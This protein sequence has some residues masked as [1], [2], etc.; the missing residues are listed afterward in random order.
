MKRVLIALL[1]SCLSVL[2]AYQVELTGRDLWWPGELWNALWCSV[3]VKDSA[4]NFIRKLKLEDF[5]LKER[6]YG[7]N[8]E[9]LS[10]EIKTF[11][12][13][14]SYKFNGTG[15]WEKSVNS[16]KLDIV[17]FID[18]TGSMGKHIDSIKHQLH[19]FIDRLFETGT[20]FRIFISTYETEDAPEWTISSYTNR[21]FG[22]TMVDEI[23]Q[24]IDEIDTAG[25]WWNLTWG[26]DAFL[27]SLNLDWRE[28][29]RKIVVIITDV[30]TD[31]VY[32]PNWYFSSGCVTSMNAVDLAIRQTHIQLYYCQ[33][34]EE[35]M[36]KTELSENYSSKVNIKVKQSNFDQLAQKN[37]MVKKLSWPF[38]Q[39]EIELKNLPVID[40]KY[41]F[42]WVSDWSKQRFVERVE[43]QISLNKTGDSVSFSFYPLQNPDGTRPYEMV[44]DVK[45]ILKDESGLSMLGERNVYVY[46]YKVMGDLDR[47]AIV[48]AMHQIS[49]KNGVLSLGTVIPGRYYYILYTH[50]NADYSYEQLG[51][52]GT[53]WVQITK[54][55]V[56]PDQITSYTL[57]KDIEIYRM[58]GLLQE[59][60]NLDISTSKMKAFVNQ[61]RDWL[62]QIR[63]DGVTLVEI[64]AIKRFNVGLG[65]IIN[66]AGYSE[67]V[68]NRATEDLVGVAQMM[69]N[70]LREAFKVAEKLES[71]MQI[72]HKITNLFVDIITGNWS[73]VA[74]NLTI[75]EV[76]DR[77]VHYI[78]NELV[79][80]II[81]T[82]EEKLLS[83]LNNPEKVLGYFHS[84]VE[85]LVK[86]LLTPEQIR[87][88]V[89]DFV[90]KDLV[91][92][93]FTIDLEKQLADLLLKS[94]I[95]VQE[96]AEK[97]WDYYKRSSLM[98]Q[99]FQD[100]RKLLMGDLFSKSYRALKD[101]SAIDDWKSV[102]I[103]FRETIPLI[104]EFIE[105]FEIRYP[106]LS[107]VKKALQTLY[108][109]LDAI[110]T[111]T[112]TYEMALKINHLEDLQS[113]VKQIPNSVYM[114]K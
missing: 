32:G 39:S 77:F 24:A 90:S 52:T 9:L 53:G 10:E 50:G 47:I 97:Y 61:V 103:V 99:D 64:E 38:D 72:F 18:G 54:D 63:R 102:L 88:R 20:D 23:R 13:H 82:V 30:Y 4:G 44:R 37:S 87:D 7:K 70:M 96:N 112:K 49:D 22:P 57:G 43:V 55:G 36:A 3:T 86:Q 68:Q 66:C 83:V 25:E 35:Q 73:G 71:A 113:R 56:K 46:F 81:N 5:T 95:L 28:D 85:N 15:F 29:A 89:F 101:Q 12:E 26:Y 42:A 60:E 106:E 111:M 19:K 84:H 76:V 41:Y 62:D 109:V 80:D 31:S 48:R 92:N 100:M 74:A 104:V 33:P 8:N 94:Q 98:R 34:S 16:D 40:S 91:Y 14:S 6:A 59:L 67:V 21:F 65:A 78:K 51:Y 58:L 108:S 110:G 114:H 79:N 45:F 105:L 93:N 75:Q 69:T 11:K 27:W 2:L 1:F 107:D 17:F